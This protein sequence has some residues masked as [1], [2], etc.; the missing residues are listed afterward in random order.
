MFTP[1]SLA[2]LALYFRGAMFGV[3]LAQ[4]HR[5]LHS[6][7]LFA[8]ATRVAVPEGHVE[9]LVAPSASWYVPGKHSRQADAPRTAAYM[10]G[11][12]DTHFCDP[13]T[14]YFPTGHVMHATEEFELLRG[15]SVPA[16]QSVHDAF[17][18]SA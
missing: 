5:T 7:K 2:I 13:V 6:V 11:E 10:P 18:G 17:S 1:L 4:S 16:G 14:A 12:H 15:F 9:Q 3:V 8:P